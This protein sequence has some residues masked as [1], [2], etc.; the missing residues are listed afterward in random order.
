MNGSIFD[1]VA[2]LHVKKVGIEEFA[3]SSEYC[4]RPLYP[5]QKVLL[6]LMFLEELSGEEEDILN[7]WINGGR[8]G[9]EI[10]ISSDIRQ[11][12][13]MLRESGYNHFREVV[14]VGGRRSSKGYVT[15][16]A[17]AKVMYD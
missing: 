4:N 2:S 16:I 14:L 10:T 12:V 1:Q 6:K 5:R 9:T 13:D 8:D 7:L 15:G 11:R 17:M 3:E